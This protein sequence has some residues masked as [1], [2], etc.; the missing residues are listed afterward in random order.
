MILFIRRISQMLPDIRSIPGGEHGPLLRQFIQR[1]IIEP[2]G[3]QHVIGI[4]AASN[5]QIALQGDARVA[6]F[7]RTPDGKP[8]RSRLLIR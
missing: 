5:T 7:E 3:D 8:Q 2:P 4:E 6:E 1:N